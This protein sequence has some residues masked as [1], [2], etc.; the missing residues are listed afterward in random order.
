MKN[1][2]IVIGLILGTQSWANT[3]TNGT[4]NTLDELLL[5]T[6]D[7]ENVVSSTSKKHKLADISITYYSIGSGGG[8]VY[9]DAVDGKIL[10]LGV[11]VKVG[12]L[13]MTENISEKLSID[14]LKRGNELPF[15]MKGSSR[16][17]LLLRPLAGFNDYGGSV[18]MKIWNGSKYDVE[19]LKI[20]KVGGSFKIMKG[21]KQ[22]SKVKINMN[23]LSLAKM[24]VDGYKIYTK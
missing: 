23:G 21:S 17:T 10:N 12:M 20:V 4:S 2:L 1:L 9:I 19:T 16:A 22:A 7:V 3:C 24:Y 8:E 6:K 5:L 13:G 18:Q 15:S 14:K 11:K